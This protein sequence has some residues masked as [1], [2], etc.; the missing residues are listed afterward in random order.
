MRQQIEYIFYPNP[1]T[2]R[3]F[4]AAYQHYQITKFVGQQSCGELKSLCRFI[5]MRNTFHL[6]QL[7]APLWSFKKKNQLVALISFNSTRRQR[8]F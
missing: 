6:T 4:L 3:S 8:G 2:L 7:F 1:K 5:T